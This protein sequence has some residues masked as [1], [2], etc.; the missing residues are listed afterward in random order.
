MRAIAREL[1]RAADTLDDFG[2]AEQMEATWAKDRDWPVV[3]V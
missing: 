2:R 1:R 3:Q